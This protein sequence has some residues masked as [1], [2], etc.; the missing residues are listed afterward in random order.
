M[1]PLPFAIMKDMEGGSVG[2]LPFAKDGTSCCSLGQAG[3]GSTVSKQ[4]ADRRHTQQRCGG[5]CQ[6]AVGWGLGGLFG[7]H[8]ALTMNLYFWA[9]AAVPDDGGGGPG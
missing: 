2:P 1:G 9:P 7:E 3:A 8:F 5:T 6:R 4:Q